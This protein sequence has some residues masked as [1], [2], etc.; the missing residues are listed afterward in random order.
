MLRK[1]LGALG[2]SAGHI[3]LVKD[4]GVGSLDDALGGSSSGQDGQSE[5]VGEHLL[6]KIGRLANGNETERKERQWQR[7]ME[8]RLQ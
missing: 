1:Q 7:I 2:R 5:A 3:E 4:L 6:V 8:L